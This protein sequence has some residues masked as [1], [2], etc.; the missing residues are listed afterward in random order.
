MLWDSK[1]LREHFRNEL[2]IN[3][4]DDDNDSKDNEKYCITDAHSDYIVLFITDITMIILIV[5]VMVK[6]L[7]GDSNHCIRNSTRVNEAG[8]G[9]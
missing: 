9:G 1:R 5:L 4:I 8:G 3:E 7:L 2:I 6:T